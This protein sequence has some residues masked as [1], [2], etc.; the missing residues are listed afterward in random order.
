M[1][2]AR[3]AALA[4][5]EPAND[6]ARD[7]AL[8]AN[9]AAELMTLVGESLLD[10]LF[11]HGAPSYLASVDGELLYAN[12]AYRKLS[13]EKNPRLLPSHRRAVLRVRERG[14]AFMLHETIGAHDN[15]RTY[16]SRHS[17]IM[18]PDGSI[19][20]VAA[21]FNDA[22]GETEARA[23]ARRERQRLQDVIRSTSDWVWETDETGAI[24]FVSDRVTEALGIPPLLV[25][26]RP[27]LGIGRF[28][29]AEGD[30]A[31]AVM[32]GRRPFR[33]APFEIEDRTGE[34]RRFHLSGVP[35]YD[36]AGRFLGFRGTASDIS[37][38]HA[39]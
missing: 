36:D 24:S 27:L 37:E 7:G 38:R 19:A 21:S 5:R 16:T 13:D 1:N 4:A 34:T 2:E 18:A 17:P 31:P 20:A 35:V 8:P 22:T 33:D 29:P 30:R 25:K 26:G 3:D 11:G 9:T 32:Q 15:A 6:H 23:R 39:A 10:A 12:A 14:E 28:V